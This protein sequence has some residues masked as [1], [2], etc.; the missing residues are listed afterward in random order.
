MKEEIK[1]HQENKTWVLQKRLKGRKT[2]K[3][4]WVF[5][6]KYNHDGTVN[7]YK[8]RLVAKG[9]TQVYGIDYEE[10]FA[11]VVQL[12]SIRTFL[13][14][15]A[16]EKQKVYQYDF[17]TAFLNSDLKETIYMVAYSP[18]KAAK[19]KSFSVSMWMT[20]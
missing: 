7:K 13:A 15:A 1:S 14:L 9:F 3:C 10:T 5:K 16:A 12:K 6:I 4:K 19:E 17:K 20:S 8:A 2:V 11:P 18:I